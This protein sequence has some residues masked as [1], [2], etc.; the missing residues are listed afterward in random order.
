MVHFRLCGNQKKVDKKRA[1]SNRLQP[2]PQYQRF[3]VFLRKGSSEAII[4]KIMNAAI[5]LLK[6]NEIFTKALLME[7]ECDCRSYISLKQI[8][9]EI[10][11]AYAYVNK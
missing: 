10:C 3:A 9:D 8:T 6:R 2:P 4:G 11:N 1:R 5:L 7:A